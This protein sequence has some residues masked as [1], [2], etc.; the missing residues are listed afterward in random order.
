MTKEG[1][2]WKRFIAAVRLATCM[3]LI[4][5]GVGRINTV[6]H[7]ENFQAFENIAPR[8]RRSNGTVNLPSNPNIPNDPLF[9]QQ[10][11]LSK[12]SENYGS[13]WINLWQRM[14][15]E[16]A[17]INETV[18]IAILDSGINLVHPELVGEL[19]TN[20]NE[21]PGDGID[22]DN[23]GYIDDVHGCSFVPGSLSCEDISD[24]SL[25]QHG[26]GTSGVMVARANNE[27]GITGEGA[28]LNIKLVVIKVIQNSGVANYSDIKNGLIYAK[29]SGAKIVLM[30]FAGWPFFPLN[31]QN[32]LLEELHQDGVIL[33]A[34]SGNSNGQ[35]SGVGW[36][37]SNPNVIAV[38]AYGRDGGATPFNSRGPQLSV[39][40][41]GV[42][43]WTTCYDG[44]E[45]SDYCLQDGTSF[46]GPQVAVAAA[47]VRT[48]RPGITPDE[49]R[50]VLQV[51]G[52]MT[53]TEEFGYGY[54][55]FDKIANE[56]GIK[57]RAYMPAIER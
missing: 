26:T 25:V 17:A 35:E 29:Q 4:P 32:A 15:V 7:D 53:W 31:Q 16:P 9:M 1:G 5:V 54:L 45:F 52:G 37:A 22:N 51:S 55:D 36:P 19:W 48:Y 33:I 57:F 18:K 56:L 6:N 23:N 30:N 39:V 2:G 28:R 41:P 21:I 44:S 12:Y 46:T 27:I 43:I 40:A 34:G 24:N 10:W 49:F 50:Q 8:T 38:G 3:S 13:N 47:L 11:N 20:P 42:D 14:D